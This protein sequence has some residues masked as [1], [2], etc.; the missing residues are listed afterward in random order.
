LQRFD[1]CNALANRLLGHIGLDAGVILMHPPWDFRTYSQKGQGKLPS[2]HYSS[3]P[4]RLPLCL[5]AALRPTIVW[6]CLWIP[7]AHT[8]I[9]LKAMEQWGFTFSGRAFAWVKTYP[10]SGKYHFG[11]GKTTRK[12]VE[13]CWLGRLGKPRVLAHDVPE[14]IIAPVREHSRK[15]DEQYPRIERLCAGPYVELFARQRWPGWIAIG[16]ETDKFTAEEKKHA[17][18]DL[19]EPI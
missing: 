8:P 11:L 19:Q 6:L 18:V 17:D 9:G 10:K 4:N 12:G 5:C 16:D 1:V 7:S 2:Q 14:L 15:P 13:D 3:L